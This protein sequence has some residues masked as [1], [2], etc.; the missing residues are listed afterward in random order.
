MNPTGGGIKE[1]DSLVDGVETLPFGGGVGA[2]HGLL[3][4][5][6]GI[7][8]RGEVAVEVGDVAVSIGVDGVVG[9]VGAELHHLGELGVSAGFGALVGLGERGDG[10]VH[11]FH[12]DPAAVF[13]ADD[14]AVVAEV[15]GDGALLHRGGA[16]GAGR[17]AVGEND[18]LGD[19]RPGL[20]A[21]AIGGRGGAGG[22][23]RSSDDGLEV[24]VDHIGAVGSV[25]PAEAVVE[26]LVDEELA[27]SDGTVGVETFFADGVD[28]GTEIKRRVRIDEEQ[29]VAGGGFGGG[30]GEA[31][32]P[33]SLGGS[34]EVGGGG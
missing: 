25:H 10:I 31:V 4:I 34:G 20:G 26:P 11:H 16:V 27:P 8:A 5:E 22:R 3:P 2:V 19:E 1:A 30:D 21:V 13:F 29:G 15:G 28:L 6:F 18:F 24:F 14:R 12:G 9:R 23:G 32:G 33:L 17:G 7:A